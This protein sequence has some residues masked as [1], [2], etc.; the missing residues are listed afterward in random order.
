MCSLS[1]TVSLNPPP[2]PTLH[3]QD[4]L[5]TL[6]QNILG[7]V[8]HLEQASRKGTSTGKI[9]HWFRA[10]SDSEPLD[11]VT[12]LRTAASDLSRTCEAIESHHTDSDDGLLV[13][14]LQS[15]AEYIVTS[16][17]RGTV[18]TSC[19]CTVNVYDIPSSICRIY[20]YL[21]IST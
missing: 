15:I 5:C 17:V 21:V 11:C 12:Y 18:H 10:I 8:S 19:T 14:N 6:E 20:K 3:I 9:G 1:F 13:Q 7:L 2:P 16:K 4:Y